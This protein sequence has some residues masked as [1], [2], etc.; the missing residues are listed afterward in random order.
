MHVLVKD[1]VASAYSL[2]QLRDDHP[3]VSFPQSPTSELLAQYQV[4]EVVPPKSVPAYDSLTESLV[5][6]AFEQLADGSWTRTYGV[7]QLPEDEA[8]NMVRSWRNDL[9]AACSW[10]MEVDAP[11]TEAQKA[12]WLSYRQALRDITQQPGFPYDVIWPE[13]P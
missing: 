12:Q 2:K 10:T 4:Y 11:L 7:Q 6:G 5:E 9:L 8:Q 3:Q 13:R 1:G